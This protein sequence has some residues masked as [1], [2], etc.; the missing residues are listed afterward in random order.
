MELAGMLGPQSADS[1]TFEVWVRSDS[2]GTGSNNGS[3]VLDSGNTSNGRWELAASCSAPGYASAAT[4]PNAGF[5][6]GCAVAAPWEDGEWHHWAI[7]QTPGELRFAFDGVVVDAGPGVTETWSVA[8]RPLRLGSHTSADAHWWHGAL[9]DARLWTRALTPAELA[10]CATKS[11]PHDTKGLVSWW[12]FEGSAADAWGVNDGTLIGGAHTA[13]A[14]VIPPAPLTVTPA[15]LS[16]GTG[17]LAQFQFNLGSAPL[18][19]IYLLIGSASGTTPGL[20]VEGIPVMLNLDDYL[21]FTV[22]QANKPPFSGSLGVLQPDGTGSATLAMAAG[23]A[24]SLAGLTLHHAL[25]VWDV[26]PGA[27]GAILVEAT[28][29]VSL[30]LL[31]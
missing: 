7:I 2:L 4:T 27:Q 30:T 23:T 31:P 29:P 8:G 3:K 14:D 26:S 17:G 21:L 11:L 12:D 16:L 10:T 6:A 25:L 19:N 20:T 22:T 13:P 1:F 28:P 5:Q 9:D 15:S 18:L 24:P